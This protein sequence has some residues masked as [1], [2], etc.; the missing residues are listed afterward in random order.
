MCGLS[1]TVFDK[2]VSV[3]SQ[4]RACTKLPSN[5]RWATVRQRVLGTTPCT[6]QSS[7]R[8]QPRGEDA[9]MDSGQIRK[10]H[11]RNKIAKGINSKEGGRE[12]NS[13]QAQSEGYV[14]GAERSEGE[15]N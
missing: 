5:Q 6:V 2:K 9:A 4:E 12:N 7:K 11:I 15:S 14:Q 3:G 1:R 10:G 13:T 8:C